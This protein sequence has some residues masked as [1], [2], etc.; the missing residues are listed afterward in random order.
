M[1]NVTSMPKQAKLKANQRKPP[2]ADV[3]KSSTLRQPK[4]TRSNINMEGEFRDGVF[5]PPKDMNTP[6]CN[7]TAWKRPSV[8]RPPVKQ[9]SLNQ[10]E[11]HHENKR[12]GE[13]RR[14]HRQRSTSM[15]RTNARTEMGEADP[16]TI[17]VF[18]GGRFVVGEDG[19]ATV[20]AALKGK[21]PYEE[22]RNQQKRR[23]QEES[24]GVESPKG[25]RLRKQ[26]TEHPRKDSGIVAIEDGRSRQL[27]NSNL[28]DR[29][30]GGAYNNSPHPSTLPVPN[31]NSPPHPLVDSVGDDSQ[32]PFVASSPISI[33]L[34]LYNLL[35]T[36]SLYT[37]SFS[38]LFLYSLFSI[39]SLS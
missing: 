14:N 9:R 18:L 8:K 37:L 31:F 34:Y 10:K 2:K 3:R 22:F 21:D 29:Y 33:S 35:D 30:A 6:P 16:E 4:S 20:E 24:G 36:L 19:A 32:A 5:V 1:C 12:N 26:P 11:K 27:Q 7:A 15:S 28:G 25:S 23:E 39:L 17:G 38:I 13:I